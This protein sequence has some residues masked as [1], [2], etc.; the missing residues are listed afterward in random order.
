VQR[1]EFVIVAG[2]QVAQEVILEILVFHVMFYVKWL[3]K[4]YCQALQNQVGN[5][6]KRKLIFFYFL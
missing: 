4:A 6:N 5:K 1:L 3:I 2:K